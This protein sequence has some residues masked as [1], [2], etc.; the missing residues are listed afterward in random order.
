MPRASEDVQWWVREIERLNREKKDYNLPDGAGPVVALAVGCFDLLHAGH[1]RLLY[2]A[3]CEAQ[4]LGGQRV[5]CY[6]CKTLLLVAINTDASVR[7]LK[8]EGRPIQPFPERRN[9]AHALQWVDGTFAFSGNPI[10]L[11][12]AL[13]PHLYVKGDDRAEGELPERETVLACGG[14][15]H[16]VKRLPGHSTTALIERLRRGE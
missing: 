10:P 1:R 7:T 13:R 11:I 8:G 2:E 6:Q 15:I 16:L 9:A 4:R 14:R 3:K 5:A 12:R